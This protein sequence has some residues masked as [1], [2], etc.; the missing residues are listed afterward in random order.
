MTYGLVIFALLMAGKVRGQSEA[1]GQ[2][3]RLKSVS[4]YPSPAT[5]FL[6]VRFESPQDKNIAVAVHNIIGNALDVELEWVDDFELQLR[7]K[8]LPTGYYLLTLKDERSQE[9]H[10]VKFLKR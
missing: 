5:E 2:K 3:T 6:Q 9:R 4:V 7:V 10:V 8:D 1:A